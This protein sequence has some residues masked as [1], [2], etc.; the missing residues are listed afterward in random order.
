MSSPT[1][2]SLAHQ[3]HLTKAFEGIAM[4]TRS[5]NRTTTPITSG[6]ISFSHHRSC[7]TMTPPLLS[8]FVTP[9]S[10]S[11][12]SRFRRFPVAC[13]FVACWTGSTLSFYPS[14]CM[15]V[16]QCSVGWRD[17]QAALGAD[18]DGHWLGSFCQERYAMSSRDYARRNRCGSQ[19]G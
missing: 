17:D 18:R 2:T 10:T 19:A 7:Q 14:S 16:W 8:A 3:E 13:R 12:I 15:S 4:T 11:R 9:T 5:R 6:T 1:L